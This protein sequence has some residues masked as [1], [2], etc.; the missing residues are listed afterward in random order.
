MAKL[1]FAIVFVLI[2]LLALFTA[3]RALWSGRLP[4]FFTSQADIE[5]SVQ[6]T[7][8]WTQFIAVVVCGLIVL[9]GGLLLFA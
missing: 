4:V 5:R 3:G 6:P 7:R 8:F 9:V 1:S 2:G